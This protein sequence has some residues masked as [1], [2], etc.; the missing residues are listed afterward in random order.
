MGAD[1]GY[2]GSVIVNQNN[3]GFSEMDYKFTADV[4]YGLSI[5]VAAQNKHHFQTGVRFLTLG[6]NY[7]AELG[8]IFT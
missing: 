2:L 7:S 4:A 1:L 3:Y 8:N 5:G 6:Q